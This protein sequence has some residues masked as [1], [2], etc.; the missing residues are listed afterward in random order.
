MPRSTRLVSKLI[1]KP[2]RLQYMR[3]DATA[4]D[5]KGPAA[6]YRGRA[7]LDAQGNVIAYDFFAKGFSRQ[8]VIQTENDPKDTLAGQFTGIAPKGEIIF[9]TPAERYEFANK[10]CGWE[11]VPP[12]LERGSP[13]RTSHFR[14][15]LGAETH[16]ASESFI[17]EL[18]HAAGADAVEVVLQR[19]DT[20]DPATYIGKGKAEELRELAVAL[21]ID[22]VIFDDELAPAQQRN[23]ERIFAVEIGRAHV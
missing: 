5:P 15:P 14:D 19:R 13:L 1:G 2:V 22:V 6:V 10:R 11:C 21:D 23:L 3:Q 16:F 17:D 20:P 12:L 4:W 9:Q 18:A 7:A 8:D